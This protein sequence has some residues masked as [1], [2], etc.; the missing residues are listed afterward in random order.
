MGS[1]GGVRGSL[2]L[3]PWEGKG[4]EG[5]W[6]DGGDEGGGSA[7]DWLFCGKG[8]DLS[9]VF[10]RRIGPGPRGETS[11]S[12]GSCDRSA[13]F[14]GSDSSGVSSITDI[15]G[16]RSKANGDWN[17]KTGQSMRE[18]CRLRREEREVPL[19]RYRRLLLGVHEQ[20]L[21]SNEWFLKWIFNPFKLSRV[22][23]CQWLEESPS[24]EPIVWKTCEP[25]WCLEE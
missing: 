7:D 14:Q 5:I 25:D 6:R 13:I 24:R 10:L 9:E 8:F 16:R 17:A 4:L 15:Q 23:G 20:D 12:M 18:Q 11:S 21:V 3:R 1:R 22:F 2:R 19:G